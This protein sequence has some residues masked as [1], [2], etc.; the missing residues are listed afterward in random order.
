LIARGLAPYNEVPDY[1]LGYMRGSSQPAINYASVSPEV[2]VE[3]NGPILGEQSAV[4]DAVF[5]LS[6]KLG[7]GLTGQ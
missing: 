6:W 2:F 5:N 7:L 1:L 3:G 4:L